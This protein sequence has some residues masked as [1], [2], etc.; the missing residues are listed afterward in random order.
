MTIYLDVDDLIDIALAVIGSPPKVRDYG[1]LSAAAARPEATAFGQDAY[2]DLAG[3]A[4]ALLHSICSNRALV[5][6]NKRLGWAAAVAFVALNTDGSVPD[7][8]TDQAEAF[9]ISVADGTLT[10]VEEIATGL[11]RLGIIS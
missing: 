8:D 5:D 4:A 10:E 7:I 11:R 3:K 2:P 1:L 9:M 6:G